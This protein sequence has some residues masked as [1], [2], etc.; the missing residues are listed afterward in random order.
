[1]PSSD[2]VGGMRMSV[3]T[4]SGGAILDL[5]QQRIE[6]LALRLESM[7]SAEASICRRPSRTM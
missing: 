6:V 2:C 5:A 3:T 1:M 7:P 4:T